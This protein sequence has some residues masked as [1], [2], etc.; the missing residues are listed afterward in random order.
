[1]TLSD[2]AAVGID[3]MRR[4]HLS[5]M[6]RAGMTVTPDPA[7]RS[8][9]MQTPAP[10]PMTV[11]SP[12]PATLPPPANDGEAPN[13]LRRSMPL[14]APALALLAMLVIGGGAVAVMM[15]M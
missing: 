5:A 10:S 7:G 4:G 2:G 6:R 12:M 13:L 15:M 1:M 8:H 14:L 11:P 9:A 3:S